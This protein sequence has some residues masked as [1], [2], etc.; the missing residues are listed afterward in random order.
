MSDSEDTILDGNETE[1][2][3]ILQEIVSDSDLLANVVMIGA[4]A[5]I[6]IPFLDDPVKAHL[7]KKL[8]RRIAEKHEINLSSEEAK[9]LTQTGGGCCAVGCLGSAV[10]W[11]IKKILRKIFFFL[12]IKRAV[13]QSTT[14]LAQAWLF[15]LALRRG[16][17]IQ[18][19]D[20]Y[21]AE[22][23]RQIIAKTTAEHG[24]KPLESA[25]SHSFEG[26]KGSLSKFAT[27]F[28]K[29]NTIDDDNIDEAVT[30]AKQEESSEI[31]GIT[32]DLTKSLTN[33][34]ESYLQK[35]ARIFEEKL[36]QEP[37]EPPA[38]A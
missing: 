14:A 32:R 4:S 12:E 24:V 35:F 28:T 7:E 37:I 9:K 5:L 31:A 29:Q 16:H 22:R 17:W 21:Q 8:F 23:L 10:L 27:K 38:K 36:A 34:S 33:I 15:T 2:G 26:A 13:D 30:K 25:V 11:P 1:E 6:P 20:L 3:Q 18:T 19:P